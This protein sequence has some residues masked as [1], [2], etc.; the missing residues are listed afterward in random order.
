MN[1]FE[2][3]VVDRGFGFAQFLENSDGAIFHGGSQ[4][5][6]LEDAENCDERAMCGGV[7]RAHFGV[8]GSHPFFHTFSAVSSHPGTLRLSNSARNCSM[9]TPA[10]SRAPRVISPLMPL[11]QS[12]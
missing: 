11:K 12:K 6:K 7:L 4:T 2:R 5:R 1:F 9:G 10:S 3:D 8:G